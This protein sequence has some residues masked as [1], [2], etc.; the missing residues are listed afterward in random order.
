MRKAYLV[1]LSFGRVN[2]VRCRLLHEIR[3]PVG[4]G[5]LRASR[6][7]QAGFRRYLGADSKP[8]G[9]DFD[10]FED[11]AG[12]RQAAAYQRTAKAAASVKRSGEVTDLNSAPSRIKTPDDAVERP[13]RLVDTGETGATPPEI[14]TL[15]TQGA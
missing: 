6:I 14:I 9:S 4:F 12:R 11:V 10:E 3:N 8:E 15:S 1:L 7:L 13:V 5:S 2:T